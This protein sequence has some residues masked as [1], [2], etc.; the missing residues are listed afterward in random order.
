MIFA[1]NMKDKKGLNTFWKK[2]LYKYRFVI[3]TDDS[4]EEKLSI[5]LS[6][7]NIFVFTGFIVF[8]CFFSTILL[9]T[10]T[11]LTE[12]VPGKATTEVQQDLFR[13]TVTAD[14]LSKKLEN[15][16]VYL[17]N[18]NNIINDDELVAPQ[19]IEG[20]KKYSSEIS[21]EKSIEDSLLRL[22]VEGE[23]KGSITISNNTKQFLMFFKP[24]KGVIIDGFNPKKKHFGIDVLAKEKTRIS[25]VLEGTVIISNWTS[26]TG[27]VI[28]VQ[29]SGGYFSLYKHNSVLLKSVGDFVNIGDH[30]AVIGNSGELSSGP[31]L[32]F[33]L[34]HHGVPV[35]PEYYIVF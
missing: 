28:G 8:F 4:F 6:R 34:W 20:T 25:V 32:H 35:N 5:K 33:E 12:Y 22:V 26:E 29:H 10:T 7:L 3:M 31:H 21:F 11:P 15:Q 23:D 18:I 1:K 24:I 2:A 13:L 27:Y 9:I 16:E 19:N 14:S 17:Q 30:I